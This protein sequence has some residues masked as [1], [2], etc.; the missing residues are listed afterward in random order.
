M[1]KLSVSTLAFAALCLTT[2]LGAQ[3]PCEGDAP[4]APD[5]NALPQMFT[6]L[7]ASPRVANARSN[8]SHRDPSDEA[9]MIPGASMDGGRAAEASE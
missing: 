6:N 8:H 9:D 5:S 7:E 4:G 3:T 2:P 1:S